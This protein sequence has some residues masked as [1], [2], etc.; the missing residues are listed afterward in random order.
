MPGERR[1]EGQGHHARRRRSAALDHV[2]HAAERE[3]EREV[4]THRRPELPALG[5]DSHV[6]APERHAQARPGRH[7]DVAP[8][9]PPR[10]R[11]GPPR[12]QV[13]R[14]ALELVETQRPGERDGDGGRDRRRLRAA[15][16]PPGAGAGTSRDAQAAR[17]LP[18]STTP[19]PAPP[20]ARAL[21]R[22]PGLASRPDIEDVL[23]GRRPTHRRM[24]LDRRPA[25]L[26]RPLTALALACPRSADCASHAMASHG[27]GRRAADPAAATSGPAPQPARGMLGW[28]GP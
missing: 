26:R 3:A 9:G 27:A 7:L 22:S 4:E 24:A 18:T 1:D 12:H 28:T 10:A 19:Q 17:R 23:D 8:G 16:P 21:M 11:A 6:V 25:A 13:V 20:T 14:D 2:G 15:A 5:S